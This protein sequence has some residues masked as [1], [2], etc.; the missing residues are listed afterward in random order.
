MMGLPIE[1]IGGALGLVGGV[2]K[3][4]IEQRGLI[5]QQTI[6]KDR[7]MVEMLLQK[8]LALADSSNAA[9]KRVEKMPWILPV[10]VCSTLFAVLFL[11]AALAFFNIPVAVQGTTESAATALTPLQIDEHWIV[12]WGYP[13]NRETLAL[14]AGIGTFVL[15]SLPSKLINRL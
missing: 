2:I 10:V 3:F 11:P 5:I 8:A 13:I 7:A 9:S 14:F 1:A 6:A 12:V 4:A 15:G